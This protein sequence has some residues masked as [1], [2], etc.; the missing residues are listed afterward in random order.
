MKSIELV[1][2]G[3]DLSEYADQVRQND[4]IV[5]TRGGKAIAALVAVDDLEVENWKLSQSPAFHAIMER[6]RKGAKQRTYSLAEVLEMMG[7]DDSPAQ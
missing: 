7:E 6:S 3:M 4:P 1:K 5:L 2:G